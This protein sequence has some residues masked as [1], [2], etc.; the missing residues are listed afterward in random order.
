[1]PFRAFAYDWIVWVLFFILPL[2]IFW[3]CATSLEEQG[4]ASG[5]PMENAAVFPRIVAWILVGL[6]VLNGVR[7]ALGVVKQPS[8]FQ[9]T[10]TTRLSLMATCS[11][12]FY[13]IV[14]PIVGYHVATPILMAVLLNGLGLSV[15]VSV[16]GGLAIS[17]TVA[18]VFQGLL[19]VVLPVGMFGITVFG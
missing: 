17:L 2:V 5:G 13:L 12:V 16:A 8:P 3:Q 18:A 1:M 19:N 11:F 14:L 6:G 9:P 4:V 7:I 10:D 15:L